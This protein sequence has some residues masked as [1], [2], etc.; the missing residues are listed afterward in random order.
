GASL[1]QLYSALIFEGPQL[2]HRIKL[3]LEKLLAQDGFANVGDAVGLDV[4]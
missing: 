2:A 4:A 1:V 3:E